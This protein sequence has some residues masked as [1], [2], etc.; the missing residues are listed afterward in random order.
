MTSPESDLAE[1]LSSI[2]SIKIYL[3]GL[4]DAAFD[5]RKGAPVRLTFVGGEFAK[6][7]GVPFERH[8]N[9]LADCEKV[10]L[11]K[12]RRRL[13]TFVE[14][15]CQDTFVITEDPAG[16]YFVAPLGAG[17]SD[18]NVVSDVAPLRFH[19]AVWAAF[20]RPLDG[21]RRFLNLEKVGFTDATEMPALGKW[22]E[23]AENYVLGAPSD[24]PVDGI[25]VQRRVEQWA[26]DVGAPVSKLIMAAKPVR[27]V[28]HPRGGS[29]QL[30][31]L[32]AIVD[33]LPPA[34]AAGW[35][36]PVAVLKHLRDAR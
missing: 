27:A 22:L 17:G 7:V 10:V 28:A 5:D 34:V 6:R 20:I 21:K 25:E 30:E 33:I 32:L 36:I 3:T 29:G 11:P 23:I 12:T 8:L 31:Q 15:Y 14:A 24:A 1:Q 13:A 19:R 4:V 35:S 18:T 2:D 26:S 9:A 16:V